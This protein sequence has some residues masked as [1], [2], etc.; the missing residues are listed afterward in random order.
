MTLL[1]LD[2]VGDGDRLRVGGKA[3]SLARLRRSGVPV[4][5]GFV[6][7]AGAAL[8]A[9]VRRDLAAAC[10][11]LGGPLAVRS[12]STAE[13]TE[14]ASFAGQYRTELDVRGSRE[15][16]EA[17]ERCLAAAAAGS[18]YGSAMGVAGSGAMAVLVQRFVEPKAAG[19][20]F[21]RHPADP[22]ALLIE[23]YSGRG[24][25]L[26]SGTVSP[27]AYVVDRRT[28]ALR[29]GPGHGALS[30]AEV[31]LVVERARRAEEVLGA[32]Q[33][34]E[35][36]IGEDGAVLLQ[37]RPITVEV[38]ERGDPRARRLTRANVGEV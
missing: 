23:A 19:V 2:E 22:T 10:E 34:V 31:P 28:G 38:E 5:D 4:P 7:E 32:P 11:R 26:V 20:A 16:I 15:A 29:S 37:S 35:W 25:A 3:Y 1:W 33:D 18:G 30:P 6:L 21:T 27:D 13:D 17:L 24:D 36:A 9:D 14:T 8:S 12:S